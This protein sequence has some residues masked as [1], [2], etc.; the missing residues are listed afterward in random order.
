MY[1]YLYGNY[2]YNAKLTVAIVAA[3]IG[4]NQDSVNLTLTARFTSDAS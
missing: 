3:F 2:A 4:A 1:P